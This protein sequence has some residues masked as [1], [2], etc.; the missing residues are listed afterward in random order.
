MTPVFYVYMEK[1]RTRGKHEGPTWADAVEQEEV[2]EEQEE[3]QLVG[4][5]ARRIVPV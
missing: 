2:I 5:G 3:Q 1:L 4:A